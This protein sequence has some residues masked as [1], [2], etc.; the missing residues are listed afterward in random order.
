MGS[1]GERNRASDSRD[2]RSF[3]G[4]FEAKKKSGET[5][6]SRRHVG[7]TTAAGNRHEDKTLR[8]SSISPFSLVGVANDPKPRN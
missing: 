5:G 4:D 6:S 7:L 3:R 2:L 1:D 8:L